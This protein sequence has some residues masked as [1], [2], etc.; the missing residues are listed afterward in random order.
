[1]PLADQLYVTHID[2]TFTGDAFFPPID[3][4]QW[5]LRTA[6]QGVQDEKN[7]YPHTF[8]IYERTAR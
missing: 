1:M 6:R 2:E 3:E 8:C 7:R 5:V 4:K